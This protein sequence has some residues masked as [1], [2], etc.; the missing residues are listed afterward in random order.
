MSELGELLDIQLSRG[1]MESGPTVL[2]L[3][4]LGREQISELAEAMS[5]VARTG[6]PTAYR[7]ARRQLERWRK[8]GV[9]LRPRSI[10]RL[11]SAKRQANARL[12]QFKQS[13]AEMKVLVSWYASRRSEWLPPNRWIHIPRE[14]MR[15]VIRQWA[16][17]DA[18]G[19]AWR[20]F[21]IFLERYDVPNVDDWLADAVVLDLR[22]E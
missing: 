5:G 22:L 7:S 9:T 6:S 16:D 21:E 1:A 12:R 4:E 18:G 19:A 2:D 8:G 15:S 13:G 10:E 14:T 3:R 20:L 17:G 11:Q